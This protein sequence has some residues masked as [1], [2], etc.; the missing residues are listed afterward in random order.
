M[1]TNKNITLLISGSIAAYKVPELVREL[2]KQNAR[3]RIAMSKSAMQFV[4]PLVLQTLSGERVLTEL[5]SLSEEFE[6][7]HINLADSSDMILSVPSTANILAKVAHGIADDLLSTVILAAKC[8]VVFFPAMNVNMWENSITQDNVKKLSQHGY[9]VINP[10][11]GELACGWTGNGR[12][13]EISTIL[14][15]VYSHLLDKTLKG[16]HVL[17]TA[18]PTQE[19]FDPVRF[20]SNSASGKMGYALA[21]MA[22]YLGAEVTLISGPSNESVPKGI[23]FIQVKSAEEMREGV[24]REVSK[25]RPNLDRQIVYMSAAV[26]DHRPKEISATKLKHDKSSDYSLTFTPC[27]DILSILGEKRIE[28]EETSLMPLVIVGFALETGDMDNLIKN[29]REKL[30]R[31]KADLIVGNFAKESLG[32]TIT[33]CWLVSKEGVKDEV[34][35]SDKNIIARKIIDSSLRI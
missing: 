34:A 35:F 1:L 10:D 22:K 17:V 6:I 11:C 5:F 26:S 14:D 15:E 9:S 18:G 19:M 20:I 29:A 3:V 4:T 28:I 33:R 8:P 13:P 25:K 23:N 7:G 31:K 21:R 27:P 30:E 12:L 24:L 16:S 32:S 2:K